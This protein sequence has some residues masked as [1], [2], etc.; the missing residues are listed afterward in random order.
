MSQSPRY[1]SARKGFTLIELL[2][3][4]AIIAVLIALL[5]PAVQSAREAARRA[6]CVNNL[7][8][9]VLAVAN[10]ESTNNTLPQGSGSDWYPEWGQNWWG[11]GNFAAMSQYFEQGV[12]YNTMNFTTPWFRDENQTA[13]GFGLSM[14]WCPSDGSI[15]TRKDIPDGNYVSGRH[16]FLVTYSSYAACTGTWFHYTM[17]YGTPRAPNPTRL[18]NMN[19]L[20]AIRSATRLAMITDGTS[21]T[22]AYGEH[23]HGKLTD[24]TGTSSPDTDLEATYWHWWCDGGYGDTMFSTM[25]P[26]NPQKKCPDSTWA[27]G[28]NG[29]TAGYIS[30]AGSFHPGGANFGFMDG[31]VRF[32]KDSIESWP[33]SSTGVPTSLVVN[34]DNTYSIVP[35]A[36][37]GVYQKLSTRAGGEVISSD[38]Y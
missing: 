38:S 8:Q 19:G 12:A 10:Y 33:I 32:L 15:S 2:V 17:N 37:V 11:I 28:L 35:G 4:I 7:K 36:R 22:I 34:A 13:F 5:L 3:V 9:V 29:G 6:Q 18:A 31:S 30:T 26:F 20:F 16:P 1:H 25:F 23:A 21:N 24:V 14:L 27:D